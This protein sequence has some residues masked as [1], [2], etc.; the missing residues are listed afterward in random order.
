[1]TGFDTGHAAASAND[2][3]DAPDV[4]AAVSADGEEVGV[5]EPARGDAAAG[6]A[7]LAGAAGEHV[8]TAM[9]TSKRAGAVLI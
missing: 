8:A 6:A 1:L 3:G 5:D 9:A 4:E 7:G 2:S